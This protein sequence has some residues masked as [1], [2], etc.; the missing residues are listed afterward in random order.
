VSSVRTLEAAKVTNGCLYFAP[1]VQ[2]VHRVG[3][4]FFFRSL[5]CQ[6]GTLQFGKFEEIVEKGYKSGIKT[7]RKWKEEGKLPIV[8]PE[9]VERGKRKG[10]GLRRNSI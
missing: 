8:V 6:F 4:S 5:V 10:R 2:E 3:A 9:G 1:S 7:L